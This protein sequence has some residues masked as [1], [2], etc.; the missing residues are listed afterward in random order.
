[1][2]RVVGVHHLLPDLAPAGTAGRA[3][4][5]GGIVENLP[6]PIPNVVLAPL[7]VVV[8][9][10]VRI[11]HCHDLDLGPLQQPS[12]LGMLWVPIAM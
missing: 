6:D 9:A 1:V 3:F 4:S 12:Q 2:L 10:A 8:T 7:D 11:A 5:P